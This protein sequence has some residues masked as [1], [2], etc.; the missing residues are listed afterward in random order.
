M[1]GRGRSCPRKSR[2][3][4]CLINKVLAPT[5]MHILCEYDEYSLK[6]SGVIASTRCYDLEGEGHDL[7]DGLGSALAPQ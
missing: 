1:A 6:R 3:R 7:E 4:S 2:S 5:M